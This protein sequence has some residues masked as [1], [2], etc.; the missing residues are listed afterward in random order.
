MVKMLIEHK[1]IFVLTILEK[2]KE[3]RLKIYLG[4]VRVL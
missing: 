1:N 4:N 3:A 2:F